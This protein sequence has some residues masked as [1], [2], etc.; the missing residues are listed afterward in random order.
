VNEVERPLGEFIGGEI[1]SGH[2]AAAIRQVDQVARVGIDRKHSAARGCDVTQPSG[3]RSAARSSLQT[4]PSRTHS[5]S[6]GERNAR[7]IVGGAQQ[8]EA[9]IGEFPVVGQRVMRI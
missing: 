4:S 2:L 1:R 5:Q 8:G 7:R 6:L 3:E 9:L